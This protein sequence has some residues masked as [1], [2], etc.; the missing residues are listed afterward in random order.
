MASIPRATRSARYARTFICSAGAG[1]VPQ[2]ESRKNRI[3]P[4]DPMSSSGFEVKNTS[5]QRMGR[6]R[7]IEI[8]AKECDLPS[9]GSQ[10]QHIV[11]TGDAPS[12][13]D[14]SLRF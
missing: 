4:P 10:K 9:G 12:R 7:R 5:I 14:E 8:F 1:A 6:A 13:L 3:R 11:L 2:P